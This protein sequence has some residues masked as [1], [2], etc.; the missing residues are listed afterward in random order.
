D[1]DHLESLLEKHEPGAVT[2]VHV[3]GCPNDMD[4]LLALKAKFGFTLLEDCCASHG[5][6]WKGKKVGTFG[7]IS[8]FSFFYG[9]HMSTIEGGMVSTSDP[10]LKDMLLLLRSH[11]WCKD[12]PPE[13]EKRLAAKYGP[14]EFNRI[15]TFYVPGYNLRS[16]DLNAKIGLMQLERLDA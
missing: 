12:V 9:H 7:E 4:R 10:D 3:L 5:S 11:G 2:I 14:P 13:T 8:T 16:S 6:T 1:L 15:F